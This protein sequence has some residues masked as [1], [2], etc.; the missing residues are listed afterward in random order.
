MNTNGSFECTCNDGFL[1]DG[2]TCISNYHLKFNKLGTLCVTRNNSWF[3]I[4]SAPENIVSCP[5]NSSESC[6]CFDDNVTEICGCFLGYEQQMDSQM[7][8]GGLLT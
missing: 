1:G 3:F 4:G 2:K 8:T 6:F 5:C 7:C